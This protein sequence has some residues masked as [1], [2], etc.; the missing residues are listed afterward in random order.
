LFSLSLRH[1]AHSSSGEGKFV[2]H[3][4]F[5]DAYMGKLEV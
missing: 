1:I 4:T 2:D 5:S 3:E